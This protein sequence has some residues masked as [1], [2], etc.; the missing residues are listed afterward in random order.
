MPWLLGL[1]A[2]ALVLVAGITRAGAADESKI[3]MAR[4]SLP[5]GF[6]IEVFATVPKAR[7]PASPRP[8]T[9]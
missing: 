4:I 6:H 7:S 3:D 1:L 8:G 2:G 9:M 5:P